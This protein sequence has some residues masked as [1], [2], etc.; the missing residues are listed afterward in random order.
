MQDSA[1]LHLWKKKF[2]CLIPLNKFTKVWL[3]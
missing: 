3:I 1:V 2:S